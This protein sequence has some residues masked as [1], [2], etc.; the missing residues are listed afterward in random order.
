MAAI[1]RIGLL[2]STESTLPCTYR[3]PF[4][5]PQRELQSRPCRITTRHEG[6]SPLIHIG[7][8]IRAVDAIHFFVAQHA[9]NKKTIRFRF[10][11]LLQEVHLPRVEEIVHALRV[12]YLITFLG[13][14]VWNRKLLDL[15]LVILFRHND[16]FLRTPLPGNVGCIELKIGTQQDAIY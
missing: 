12:Q 8:G 6:K 13:I 11:T 10:L 3:E 9:N 4:E 16:G 15:L 7:N 1:F 2:N 14:S 5:S